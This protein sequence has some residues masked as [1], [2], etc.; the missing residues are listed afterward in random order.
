MR[1]QTTVVAT[2][3]F[4]C[5]CMQVFNCNMRLKISWH[6]NN[7]SEVMLSNEL[8][9]L[10]HLA[11]LAACLTNSRQATPRSVFTV[12]LIHEIHK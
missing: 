3:C 11:N 12:L 1:T 5:M 8:H 9:K 6:A 7:D 4:K 2:S 10:N